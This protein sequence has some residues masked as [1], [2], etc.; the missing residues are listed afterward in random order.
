MDFRPTN[1]QYGL[2][3]T[4]QDFMEIDV[5]VLVD[6]RVT[7]TD[8]KIQTEADCSG[9]LD[10]QAQSTGGSLPLNEHLNRQ[11]IPKYSHTWL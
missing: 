3:R 9:F 2:K 5:G 4:A 7:P 6:F 8:K 10:S 1:K 11:K